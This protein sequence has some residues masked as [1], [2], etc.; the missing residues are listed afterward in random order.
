MKTSRKKGGFTLIELLV[1][2]AIIAIL[3]AILFPVFAKAREAARKASCQTNMKEIALAFNMYLTD[4]DAKCFTW[5]TYSGATG[6][7]AQ[8]MQRQRGRVPPNAG[9]PLVTWAMRLNSHIKNKEIIWCPSDSAQDMSVA[10]TSVSVS[11]WLKA[12]IDA[13]YSGGT[14]NAPWK[15]GDFNFPSEQALFYE[16]KTFHWGSEDLADGKSVNVAFFDN[17]VKTVRLVDVGANQEPDFFN[18]DGAGQRVF[19]A[20]PKLGYD[21]FR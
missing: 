16:N 15:E 11:Y 1:V 19:G 6:A 4:Y 9:D 20:D 21:E 5:A 17:H 10:A 7:S 3:A 12:C 18:R 2:I 13:N 14:A 8:A